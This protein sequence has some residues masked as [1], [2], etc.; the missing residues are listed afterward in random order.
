MAEATPCS[1]PDCDRP[2]FRRDLCSPHWH[3]WQRHG[4]PLAGRAYKAPRGARS[5]CR[6]P[7]CGLP[8][9]ADYLCASHHGRQQRHGDPLA[10]GYRGRRRGQKDA[11]CSQEGCQARALARDLC[12]KHYQRWR[13]HGDPAAVVQVQRKGM[14]ASARLWCRVNKAGPVP[15]HRP[16]LGPCWVWT[17][18]VNS[19]GYATL[20][21]DGYTM[22]AHRFAYELERGKIPDQDDE[23]NPLTIDHLCRVRRCCRPSHMEVVTLAENNR[24]AALVRWMA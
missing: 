12:G 14:P 24:R 9:L 17:E 3:R 21:V 16:D 4:D 20:T 22:M 23:G 5:V 7:G 6:I 8:V 11:T 15:A 13:K 19:A 2:R 10:G 1:I 18:P